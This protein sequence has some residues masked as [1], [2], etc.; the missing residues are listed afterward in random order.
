MNHLKK[1][2]IKVYRLILRG[3]YQFFS[4]VRKH[5]NNKVIIALYRSNELEGNLK[6]IYD[7]LNKQMPEAEIHLVVGK[8][9]MNLG[10][11]KEIIMLSNAHYLILD[12]YYL[13]V[14]LIHP[15]KNL[16]VIQLWHAAGAFKKFGYS[17]VGTKFGP[18]TSYLEVVPIHSNYTHVYVSSKKVIQYY[19]DAF[20]MS[21]MNIFPL[22]IPRTD[23]FKDEKEK[24]KIKKNIYDDYPFLKDK[25]NILIAPTY[26]AKGDQHES[27]EELTKA[28]INISDAINDNLHIIFKPHPYMD[29]AELN[30]LEECP[31]VLVTPNY[32]IN[33]WMLISDAFV[34]DYSSSI[35]EFALLKRPLA[36]FIPDINDYVHNRGFYQDISV[37]SDGEQLYNTTQLIEWMN[38]R[39]KHEHFDSSRMIH[40]NF[41][42]TDNVSE[43][44]VTHFIRK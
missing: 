18:K 15:K 35:F 7:E 11:F 20:Q 41:D 28:I 13:P 3:I 8:N 23:L 29:K 9:K 4:L 38:R 36:H 5:D 30:K 12:D 44:I 40:Y 6:Y 32:P 25:V 37:I 2:Y 22:G 21:P 26:R 43:R 19:A 10:L 33:E 42:Y 39:K 1:M 27:D 14:Y 24:D 31:N 17:T 34:T 16:K